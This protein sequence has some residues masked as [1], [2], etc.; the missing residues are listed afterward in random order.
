VGLDEVGSSLARPY[1]ETSSLVGLDEVGASLVG[2]G[3]VGASLVG[4]GVITL[5]ILQASEHSV[6]RNDDN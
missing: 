3:E 4:L 5:A 1:G 6:A 2:L